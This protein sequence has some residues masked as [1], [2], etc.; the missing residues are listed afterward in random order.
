MDTSFNIFQRIMARIVNKEAKR[1]EIMQAAIELFLEKGYKSVTT[2]EI[3]AHAGVSKGVLYDYFKSKEDLFFQTAKENVQKKMLYKIAAESK[4]CTPRERFDLMKTVVV[5]QLDTKQKRHRLIA[6][7]VLNCPDRDFVAEVIG[8]FIEN[9]RAFVKSIL[10]EA[11]AGSLK[12]DE[13]AD[14]FANVIVVFIDGV[15]MQYMTTFDRER[16]IRTLDLFWET[17]TRQISECGE[18]AGI[19]AV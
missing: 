18:A 9:A 1:Q 7:F 19:R 5:E 12:S 8:H 3:S 6:D 13:E 11:F 16:L 15:T 4:S 17:I 10:T 2:R 14:D